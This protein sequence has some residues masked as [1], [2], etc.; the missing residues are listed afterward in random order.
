MRAL[1]VVVALCLTTAAWAETY[2]VPDAELS[3]TEICEAMDL[4]SAGDTVLVRRGVYDSVRGYITPFGLKTAVV[5]M[6]DGVTLIGI[7]RE[8]VEIDQT[9][10]DYGILC[11]DVGASTVI[12]NL[13]VMASLGRGR[14][15]EDEGDGR[16]LVA[17]IACLTGANLTIRDV[18]IENVSTGIVVRGEDSPSAP[19][20]E[21]TLVARGGHQGIYVFMNGP[22]P[23]VVDHVTLVENFDHG[24]YAYDATVDVSSCNITHNEKNG[25]RSYLASVAVQYSNVFLNDRF[26]T[27]PENYG[28]MADPTGTDGNVSM[29]PYY[30]DFTG[31]F[32]YDYHVCL[33]SDILTLGEGGSII[34]AFGGACSDCVSPVEKSSWGAI[35]ALYR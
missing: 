27:V 13:T 18:T 23:V 15:T 19:V 1:L 16:N 6:T 31:Q 5:S 30:C 12:E 10:A 8:D 2:E 32:G 11:T 17:G 3:I 14:G 33:T 34:G 20:I 28:G 24:I 7:D 21:N 25:I 29:E 26:S 4:A 9:E 35:K 22:S